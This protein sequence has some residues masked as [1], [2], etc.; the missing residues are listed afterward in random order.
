M[1]LFTQSQFYL[2]TSTV[3]LLKKIMILILN[4]M[5]VWQTHKKISCEVI[6]SFVETG[7]ALK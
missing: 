3:I 4:R 7:I 5:F 1:E 6:L 2:K